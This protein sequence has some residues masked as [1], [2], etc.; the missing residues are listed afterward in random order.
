M[1]NSLVAHPMTCEY[2]APKGIFSEVENRIPQESE[3]SNQHIDFSSHANKI[4]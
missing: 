4:Q 3:G 2:K 1:G